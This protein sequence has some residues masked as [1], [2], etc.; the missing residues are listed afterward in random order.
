MPINPAKPL[1]R[2]CRCFGYHRFHSLS[3]LKDIDPVSSKSSTNKTEV[4]KSTNNLKSSGF[5][6]RR[7]K[8]NGPIQTSQEKNPVRLD[9]HPPPVKPPAFWIRDACTCQLCVDPSTKQK[10]FQTTDVPLNIEIASEEVLSNGELRVTWKNDVTGYGENH[11]T[12]YSHKY[13]RVFKNGFEAF[14]VTEP[15]YWNKAVISDSVMF[16]DFEKLISSDSVLFDALEQLQIYGLVIIRGVPESETSVEDIG[17]RIGNLKDTLYGR[18]W[19]V[20]SIAQAKNIAYTHQ[21]L[22]LHMDL[23]YTENPPK[24]QLLHCLKN[25]CEGG[26]SLFSDSFFAATSIREESPRSYDHLKT[27]K[28]TYHYYNGGHHYE[29]SRETIVESEKTRQIATVN[30]S[31][32]FQAPFVLHQGIISRRS[33]TRFEAYMKALKAFATHI[34]APENIHEYRIKEG[35]CVIFDNRRIL[36]ARR[37][38]DVNSGE[39]WLKGAYL[40]GDVFLSRYTE[41]R[42]KRG[43]SSSSALSTLS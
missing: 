15:V 14:P 28:T 21:F 39:R 42:K 29:Q 38:F 23:L 33:T 19:D 35:E 34:E 36:H 4:F 17:L 37:A 11:A 40:D 13:L 18:T 32:P 26:S 24:L 41:L 8:I 10:L 9:P 43:H 5:H 20:K 27:Y 25:S 31:P 3:F 22:G 2:A 1:A 16:I 30:W 6:I 7:V 12:T